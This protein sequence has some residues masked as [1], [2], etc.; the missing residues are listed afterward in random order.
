[1]TRQE[2]PRKLIILL[3]ALAT[4]NCENRTSPATPDVFA[5]PYF[6]WYGAPTSE[7]RAYAD[8]AWERIAPCVGLD[9]KAMSDFPIVLIEAPQGLATMPWPLYAYDARVGKEVAACGK[10]SPVRIYIVNLQEEC[11]VGALPTEIMHVALWK[12]GE[13]SGYSNPK[14]TTCRW[15]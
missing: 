3:A 6:A 1:M 12:H 11:F 10:S 13:D 7:Q 2:K 8:M 15:W 14:F 9:T 4:C 5:S